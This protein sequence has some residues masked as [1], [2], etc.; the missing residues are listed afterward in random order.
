[1][2]ASRPAAPDGEFLEGGLGVHEAALLR[3]AALASAAHDRFAFRDGAAAARFYDELY[4]RGGADFAP[5]AGR[6]LLVNGRP[7]G[8]FALVPPAALQRSRL[9]GAMMLVRSA[10][11]RHDPALVERLK[12]AA[13]TFVRPRITDGYLSRLAVDPVMAGRGLGRRLL[14]GALAAT[15][16]LGL[17][18]CV[19]EVDDTNDRAIALYRAAGFADIGAQRTSDPEAGASLGYLHMAQAV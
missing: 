15:R 7:A 13:G 10:Q 8:M 9:V 1:M 18:R 17:A 16:D 5:P 4:R 2:S 19:L 14:D 12:L 3:L 6:L 11:L